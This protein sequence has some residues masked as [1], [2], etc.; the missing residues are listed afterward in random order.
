MIF[1]EAINQTEHIPAKTHCSAQTHTSLIYLLNNFNS[2]NHYVFASFL[3]KT[4]MC[5]IVI[6]YNHRRCSSASSI[7]LEDSKPRVL[8]PHSVLL[9]EGDF[10]WRRMSSSSLY[11]STVS[12]FW[13]GVTSSG[14][15]VIPLII[16]LIILCSWG[17]INDTN[18]WMRMKSQAQLVHILCSTAYSTV[19]KCARSQL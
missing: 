12:R 15:H 11:C 3:V 18:T 17:R 9:V 1:L 6:F 2:L 13:L 7:N 10:H 16:P 19:C 5:C 4:V 8:L 14:L